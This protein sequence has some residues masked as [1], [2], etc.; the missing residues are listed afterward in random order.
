[1]PPFLRTLLVWL[2]IFAIIALLFLPFVIL[3]R[4]INKKQRKYF[5]LIA[6]KYNLEKDLGKQKL[7][8]AF[9]LVKGYI[10]KRWTYVQATKS[11]HTTYAAGGRSN[12]PVTEIAVQL[13]IPEFTFF[14]ISRIKKI[15][16]KT[17]QIPISEFG[18]Y[19]KV[20]VKHN[21]AKTIQIGNNFKEAIL[22]YAV[23]FRFD[24]IYL[25]KD[26]IV[27]GIYA[28]FTKE[29]YYKEALLRIELQHEIANHLSKINNLISNALKIKPIK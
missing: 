12:I 14:K 28:E 21:N 18:D 2:A 1:M 22:K 15:R 16:K 20:E 26:Y 9:P 6:E 5:A 11:R 24:Y 17:I 7:F 25:S 23:K 4:I 10:N 29:E 27:S 13:K 19:Y 8:K 3:Y